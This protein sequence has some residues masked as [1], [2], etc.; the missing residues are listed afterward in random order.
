MEDLIA[1][2]LNLILRNMSKSCGEVPGRLD[3]LRDIVGRDSGDMLVGPFSVPQIGRLSFGIGN[4]TLENT[5]TVRTSEVKFLETP[6]AH[7]LESKLV[8]GDGAG[9][10]T[11]SHTRPFRFATDILLSVSPWNNNGSSVPVAD[12]FFPH[13][14]KHISSTHAQKQLS[15]TK[16]RRSMNKIISDDS[17][18]CS[19]ARERPAWPGFGRA[20]T[21]GAGGAMEIR[22]GW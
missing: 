20:V 1:P 17:L 22:S 12:R 18:K 19:T 3:L 5:D 21:G 10:D 6:E 8:L 9:T 14:Q 2:K 4:L 7:R 15:R 16:Q 13:F 11:V